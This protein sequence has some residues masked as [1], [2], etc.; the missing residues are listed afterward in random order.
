ML[1][2]GAGA[3]L[4]AGLLVWLGHPAVAAVVVVV[5]AMLMLATSLSDAFA[6]RVQRVEQAIE[7]GAGAVLST[8]LLG[9]I[10]LLVFTPVWLILR[11]LRTNPLARGAPT[12]EDSFWLPHPERADRPLHSRPFA[13]ERMPTTGVSRSIRVRAAIGLVVLIVLA[14]L[15]L[16]GAINA[17][18]DPDPQS[19]T[20][21][22]GSSP[23][24]GGDEP[25]RQVIP[26]VTSAL[27]QK[28]Y[29]PF[30]SFRVLDYDGTFVNV[31]NGIR[32][33]HQGPAALSP[34]AVSVYFFGGSSMFG[35]FQRDGH[36]IP[37]EFAR[38]AEADG[39]PVRVSNYGQPAYV[40]WQEVLL[41]Q[42]LVAGGS[43]PDLAVFYDG[44]NELLAQFAIGEHA[45]PTQLEARIA[46]ERLAR[47][48]G[49]EDRSFVKR[50][51]KSWADASAL[52]RLG[53]S[54]GVLSE[55][56]DAEDPLL[57]PFKGDQAER[58]EAKAQQAARIYGRGV[59]LG[60]RLGNSYG[61]SSA[62]FWQ[63]SVYTRQLVEAEE[64][65]R[66]VAGYDA[67]AW[68]TATQIARDRMPG[69]VV[70]LSTTLDGIRE[71]VMYDVVHTNERGA[72]TIAAALYERLKPQLLMLA[73][74]QRQ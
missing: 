54:V 6:K 1:R 51:Y 46:Q 70:D 47:G 3:V 45:D 24:A 52:H 39:I 13:Y 12:S 5:I 38:L 67:D 59:E 69:Q 42:S 66:S 19:A 61:F 53:R 31:E 33:S 62:F 44:F 9:A 63:P 18:D 20:A 74:E 57:S 11:L 34:Q 56:E 26:E 4:A 55:P 71:P 25:W 35:A 36:T 68:T 40:N 27:G 30:L 49:V 2:R 8:V 72:R 23:P 14:D 7:R 16:G 17:L 60:S 22:T 32:R 43:T 29:D 10:Q 28:S 73:E 48:F 21:L 15:A 64:P 58:V 50:A 65:L 37:S 41:L